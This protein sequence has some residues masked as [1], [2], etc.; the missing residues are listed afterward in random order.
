MQHSPADSPDLDAGAAWGGYSTGNAFAAGGDFPG[1]I[2]LEVSS[3]AE[4]LSSCF[5]CM[6]PLCEHL[7]KI[8]DTVSCCCCCCCCLPGTD[9]PLCVAVPRL[10]P[11]IVCPRLTSGLCTCLRI[12]LHVCIL[13]PH[14]W[15]AASHASVTLRAADHDV[16]DVCMFML[17][18][19]Y[20]PD[21]TASH[22]R[23]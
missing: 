23:A 22:V 18:L 19:D 8:D 6:L 1:K 5:D 14:W 10:L 2:I 9:L 13:H 4:I 21:L 17:V 15:P 3:P 20:L 12:S 16:M 11:R 7:A